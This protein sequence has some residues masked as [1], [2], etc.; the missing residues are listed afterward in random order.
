MAGS[1]NEVPLD[2]FQ[3]KL[4]QDLTRRRV[5]PGPRREAG[6]AGGHQTSQVS[7]EQDSAAPK[8]PVPRAAPAEHRR[9]T[10]SGGCRGGGRPLL[11]VPRLPEEPK[12]P[13]TVKS[14]SSITARCFSI[15]GNHNNLPLV[16]SPRPRCRMNVLGLL[17][18]SLIAATT[19]HLHAA[20][21]WV[22]FVS[23]FFWIL[24]L[25]FLV[26]YL[27]QL[28]QKFYM[29]PWPLVLMI[30]NAA[31]TVLYITAFV[32][33][34]AAVQP[35]SWRQWD[36]NRRAAASFFACVT[37]ITYG[38]STFFSFRAWKGLGS[39]AATSQV[40]DHA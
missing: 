28:H 38:V 2:H 12:G 16:L 18:W 36:Y 13:C 14:S 30:C 27:L 22:M 4:F 29:V 9:D 20:Y 7:A 34:A 5:S 32:T 19:Y 37:M 21:G 11:A 3:P 8:V 23:L 17:V 33:C 24:T 40:T 31:A 25:L 15:G 10:G 26:T 1:W 39:N 6:C 35:T